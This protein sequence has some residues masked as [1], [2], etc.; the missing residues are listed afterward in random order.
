MPSGNRCRAQSAALARPWR[1][2]ATARCT[3]PA[4]QAPTGLSDSVDR[5]LQVFQRP[6]AADSTAR[7]PV[8]AGHC[9]R[10]RARQVD[11]TSGPDGMA[12]DTHDRLFVAHPSPGWG[13]GPEPVR[14]VRR[15]PH[16]P[17]RGHRHAIQDA[18]N[19][20]DAQ[21]AAGRRRAAPAP[22]RAIAGQGRRAAPRTSPR[23][24]NSARPRHPSPW[25]RHRRRPAC[26]APGAT[27]LQRRAPPPAAGLRAPTAR[28]GAPAP[29]SQR[30]GALQTRQPLAE[31][32]RHA[33][34]Q[35]QRNPSRYCGT[36]GTRAAMHSSSSPAGR[37]SCGRTC[38]ATRHARARSSNPGPSPQAHRSQ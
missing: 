35:R 6:A 19:A 31:R 29:C 12:I 36:P 33:G 16:Q 8:H 1:A 21:A 30:A 27:P 4:W 32:L 28:R 3:R 7:L 11:G 20:R 38:R 14:R 15:H 9:A 2:F 13:L 5:A 17:D 37:I 18:Q 25:R 10:A 26:P 23:A 34:L 24:R 22:V